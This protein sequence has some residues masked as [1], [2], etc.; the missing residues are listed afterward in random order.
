MFSALFYTDG[1]PDKEREKTGMEGWERGEGRAGVGKGQG[2]WG[3]GG[4]GR[5][6]AKKGRRGRDKRRILL[7]RIWREVRIYGDI[8]A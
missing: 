6:V 4:G 1:C 2:G 8:N 3:G 5:G 7:V